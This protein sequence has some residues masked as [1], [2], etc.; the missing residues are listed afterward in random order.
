MLTLGNICYLS[1]MCFN[2]WIDF[3]GFNEKA[4]SEL[5]V[6]AQVASVHQ[7]Y[8]QVITAQSLEKK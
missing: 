2:Y 5:R 8:K 4:K 3:V 7:A 6:I 1:Y